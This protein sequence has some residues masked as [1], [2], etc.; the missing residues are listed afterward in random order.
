MLLPNKYLD[1][2]HCDFGDPYFIIQKSNWFYLN[3]QNGA[4]KVYY[5]KAIRIKGQVFN[6]F[7]KFIYQIKR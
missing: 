4:M 1:Y 2:L 3:I 7:Q 5:V 6:I